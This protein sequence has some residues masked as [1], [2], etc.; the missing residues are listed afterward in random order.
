MAVA[1][2]IGRVQQD[3]CSARP[4]VGL[5][6]AGLEVPHAHLHVVPID[7]MADLDFAN[8]AAGPP[9]DFAEVAE[10]LR[11]ALRRR[12]SRR[13]VGLTVARSDRS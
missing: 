12:R 13:G 4:R 10:R 2:R 3:G 5:M 9:D 1:H 7:G 8:A 6:I 11:A